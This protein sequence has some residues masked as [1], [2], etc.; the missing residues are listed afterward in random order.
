[1][2]AEKQARAVDPRCGVKQRTSARHFLKQTR[3]G[4]KRFAGEKLSAHFVA[5]EI[6]RFEQHHAY[7]EARR[8][9]GSRTSRRAAADDG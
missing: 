3:K 1:V 6:A 5:G 9:N 2:F 8:C 4:L 7:T